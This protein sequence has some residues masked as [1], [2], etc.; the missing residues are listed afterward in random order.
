MA[1]GNMIIH[2]I[3]ARLARKTRGSVVKQ[4]MKAQTEFCTLADSAYPMSR[5]FLKPFSRRMATTPNHGRFHHNLSGLRT[6]LTENPIGNFI[7]LCLSL[8]CSR[9]PDIYSPTSA[10]CD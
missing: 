9:F 1:D 8:Y 5:T 2:S 3:D 6:I 4:V 10:G 7:Q